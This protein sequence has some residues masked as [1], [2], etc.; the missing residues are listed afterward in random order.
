MSCTGQ[1]RWPRSSKREKPMHAEMLLVAPTAGGFP[2]NRTVVERHR[3]DRNGGRSR[4]LRRNAYRIL[5]VLW[6]APWSLLGLL[7]GGLGLLS[8]GRVQRKHGLLEFWGGC[9]PAILCVFPFYFGSPVA[10]F[11]HVVLGRSD[12]H[13]R[14]CRKHQFV[15]VG[16]TSGGASYSCPHTW[17][18]RPCSGAGAGV[19]TTT[20]PSS[21]RRSF[22]RLE[23]KACRE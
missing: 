21:D 19:R 20:I 22:A 3:R 18:A 11:G 12:R 23:F 8:G 6:A 7:L 9:L 15:H 2:A 1:A 16:N 4:R 17:P 13:L 5:R 14:A 10:T